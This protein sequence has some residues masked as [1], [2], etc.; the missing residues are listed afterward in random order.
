MLEIVYC[1]CGMRIYKEWQTY[2]KMTTL[3]KE[4]IIAYQQRT[5]NERYKRNKRLLEETTVEEN[6]KTKKIKWI[7]QETI[8]LD[9]PPMP[10]DFV[11]ELKDEDPEFINKYS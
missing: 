8:G 4:R 2:H 10:F 6:M 5:M 1:S 11:K 9:L 3:H 7:V